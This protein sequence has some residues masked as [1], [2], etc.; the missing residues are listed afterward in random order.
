MTLVGGTLSDMWA[1]RERGKAMAVFSLMPFLGPSMGP[2]IGGWICTGVKDENTSRYGYAW[3]WI[4]W[5]LFIFLFVCWI[6]ISTVPETL[7]PVLLT[8]RAKRLRAETGDDSYRSHYELHKKSLGEN[9]R[10]SL[11]RPII[12]LVREPIVA[13]ISLYMSVIY[14]C[15]YM[16][17]FA[18]PYV[19]MTLKGYSEGITGLMFLPIVLGTLIATFMAP[20]INNHYIRLSEQ[21]NGRPPAEMR[22]IP[23]MYGCWLVPIGLFS[24]AWTT[25]PSLSWAGP[26][27]SAIP[28][29]TGFL[30]LYNSAN[31]Y[32]VDCYQHYAASALAAKTFVRSIW[33][34]CVVLFTLQ[35]YARLNAQW[36]TSLIA[37]ICLAC[38]AIP[39]LFYFKGA[40][41]RKF[42]KYAYSPEAEE[43]GEKTTQV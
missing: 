7:A 35:M 14:G 19:Y 32:L 41:I 20:F 2:L 31:N 10:I 3:R 22:L 39:Y 5:V 4:Y 26:A 38:C 37:F 28:C 36:A 24:F 13:L 1:I 29:G 33:G 15:L 25:Y 30:L 34:A 21:Y 27:F 11:S 40:A 8:R 42:S 18:Y 6:L 12:L 43:N 9:L 23:M 16:F 17:F